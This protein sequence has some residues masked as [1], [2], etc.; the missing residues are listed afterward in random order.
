MGKAPLD[1]IYRRYVILRAYITMSVL[2][3]TLTA[4][5]EP[6][7]A[8]YQIFS[9]T[10]IDHAL[11]WP[12]IVVCGIAMIDLFVNDFLPNKYKLLVLYHKR[13][14][15]YMIFA[16]GMFSISAVI[17]IVHGSTFYLARLW[18]DGFMAATV[19]ILDIFARHKGH[20][21]R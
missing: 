2:L 13:H 17:T 18:I 7:S 19:A 12:L 20:S 1:F 10:Q 4:M 9:I 21:W 16:F 3:S 14:V 8:Y 6:S 15:F 11:L 5:N